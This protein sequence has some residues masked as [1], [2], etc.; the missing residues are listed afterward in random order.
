[1]KEEEAPKPDP[2][3][4]PVAS[5]RRE[6]GSFDDETGRATPARALPGQTVVCAIES[7]QVDPDP[8]QDPRPVPGA[9]PRQPLPAL[10]AVHTAPLPLPA[11][12]SASDVTVPPA[13]AAVPVTARPSRRRPGPWAIALTIAV[14]A[15]VTLATSRLVDRARSAVDSEDVTAAGATTVPPPRESPP[16]ARPIAPSIEQIPPRPAPPPLALV[17]QVRPH[18]LVQG[19]IA[20]DTLNVRQQPDPHS[21]AVVQIPADGRGIV[22]TGKRRQIG[23]S[24]WWEV[25]YRGHHGWV[26]G[27]FL[28]PEAPP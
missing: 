8:D 23:A 22:A 7:F 1:M 17:P 10:P 13:P 4:E 11:L 12:L 3:G 16:P 20:P 6:L 18:Y 2:T 21:G 9:I 5:A 24:A 14:A 27:R 19:V 25:S 15:G 28:T 26:N